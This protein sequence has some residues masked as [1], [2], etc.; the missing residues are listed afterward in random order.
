MTCRARRTRVDG[1]AMGCLTR[2]QTGKGTVMIRPIA[3]FRV[4]D[5]SEAEAFERLV[6][7]LR[8]GA[9]ALAIVISTLAI[10]LPVIW[11]V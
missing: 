9:V 7:R 11:F 6:G 3:G 10:T 2:G 1:F 4:D 5:P 8:Y